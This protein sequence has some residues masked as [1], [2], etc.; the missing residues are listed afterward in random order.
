MFPM[1]YYFDPTVLI[2][3]P[4]TILAIVA[5]IKVSSTFNK[6]NNVN[7]SKGYTGV[8][9]AKSLLHLA[10]I[11]DVEV[12]YIRGN[13]T[14]HYDPT[15]KKIRLSDNVYN[16]T[17]IAAISVAAHETGHAIQHSEN[18]SFLSFRSALFPAVN[19]SSKIAWPLIALGLVFSYLSSNLI[20]LKIGIALFCIVVLFQIVTLPVE[21]NA[22]SRAIKLL[23]QYSF[24]DSSEVRIS[25]KVLTA[26]A[27]TYVAAALVGIANL[28]RLLIILNSRSRD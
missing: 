11:N 22:S 27:L 21:F 25:K 26:A 24:L 6:Y 8:E 1:Y 5:Q 28:L 18:Y 14:D 13:L 17:S 19:F 15:S 10:G 12:E 16:S 9:V 4:A 20:V 3:L 2:I 7:S 23:K